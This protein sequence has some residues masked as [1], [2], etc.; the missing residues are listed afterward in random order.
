MRAEY[1]IQATKSTSNGERVTTS[2]LIVVN[3]GDPF[4]PFLIVDGNVVTL[5]LNELNVILQSAIDFQ[6]NS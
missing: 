6:Q 4:S 3:N 5:D 1:T 2:V